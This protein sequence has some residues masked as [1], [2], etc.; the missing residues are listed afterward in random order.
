MKLAPF[1]LSAALAARAAGQPLNPSAAVTDERD[2]WDLFE[3]GQLSANDRDF[4]LALLSSPIPLASASRAELERIPGLSGR[5]I[6]CL[7]AW[8]AEPAGPD[9][10]MRPP[11]H[12]VGAS[13]ALALAPF[14]VG[15]LTA[16]VEVSPPEPSEW[17]PHG[18]A[19][20]R[21]GAWLAS[22]VPTGHVSARG[23][24][25]ARLQVGWLGV[26]HV[27][28]ADLRVLGPEQL[29]A[30]PSQWRFD[31]LA[32][33]H[34]AAALDLP[35][36]QTLDAVLG[37]YQIRFSEGL[38]LDTGGFAGQRGLAPDLAV[39]APSLNQAVEA[40]DG[41][42]GVAA[43][44]GAPVPWSEGL[45][46]IWAFGSRRL[47]KVYQYD[48]A[49]WDGIGRDE[50]SF[51]SLP[52]FRSA[53]AAA[54]GAPQCAAQ[55]RCLRWATFDD[56]VEEWA[57]GGRV[58]LPAGA[59][60]HLGVS[61][62]WASQQFLAAPGRL[63]FAPAAAFPTRPTFWALGADGVVEGHAWRLSAEVAVS[64]T[65]APAAFLRTSASGHGFELELTARYLHGRFDNPWARPRV[66]PDELLGSAAR[67]EAG[68]RIWS[69]VELA[70]S[71]ILE[72]S[73]DVWSR[74]LVPIVSLEAQLR[75][76]WR[77]SSALELSLS[78]AYLDRDLRAS[79]PH[80]SVDGGVEYAWEGQDLYT[81]Q[82]FAPSGAVRWAQGF[83]ANAT[84]GLALRFFRRFRA[85][86]SSRLSWRSEG[87]AS[88]ARLPVPG[89]AFTA[90][91]SA[92]LGEGASAFARAR[93]ADSDWSTSSRGELSVSGSAG[94]RWVFGPWLDLELTY[95]TAA[96][97][98]ADG[99]GAT[100][101]FARLGLSSS[102]GP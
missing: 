66:Q 85:S 100:E 2:L 86:L 79:G 95:A 22:P 23:G 97:R 91:L 63:V 38:V 101:H 60:V 82:G 35:S 45:A 58:E 27:M 99:W 61:G 71:F 64:H 5:A 42:F 94:L 34:V 67:D 10:H 41:L 36:G 40:R 96:A 47:R 17:A 73:L 98:S 52:V 59:G 56:A 69:S 32:K 29:A 33:A 28:A 4:L 76:V 62:V 83:A 84:A 13:D 30:S 57:A 88:T 24:L 14:F 92:A 46:A 11:A 78:A 68:A 6:R 77:P 65:L 72:S 12:C 31:P 55:G 44:F 25:G 20:T 70:P 87:T 8:V 74:A 102:W 16:P 18:A 1:V 81:F 9:G 39:T 51:R 21:L 3:D 19:T 49:W 37:S 89:Y 48:A 80:T 7:S 90:R 53:Q 54:P 75:A 43:R 93:L 50:D 15:E 26:F